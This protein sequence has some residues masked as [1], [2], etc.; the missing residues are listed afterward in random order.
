M[1]KRGRP[2]KKKILTDTVSKAEQCYMILSSDDDE[3]GKKDDTLRLP[4]PGQRRGIGNQR[5]EIMIISPPDRTTSAMDVNEKP[6]ALTRNNTNKKKIIL[7]GNIKKDDTSGDSDATEV[8]VHQ[9]LISSSSFWQFNEKN[10][11]TLFDHVT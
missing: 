1:G 11:I 3:T 7:N 2:P 10:F 6:T 5:S 4:S 9:V 8:Y